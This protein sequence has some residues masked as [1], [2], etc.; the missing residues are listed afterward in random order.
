MDVGKI[1]SR[2]AAKLCYTLKKEQLDAV[3][4]FLSGNDVFTILPTGY[5]KSLCYACLPFAFDEILKRSC[6]IAVIITPLTAIMKDQV[7]KDV[8]MLSIY[9]LKTKFDH[10]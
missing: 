10:S 1:A 2:S 6:S 9:T 3:V 8:V 7:R 5:G 4:G